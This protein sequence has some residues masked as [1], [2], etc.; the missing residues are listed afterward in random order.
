MKCLKYIGWNSYNGYSFETSKYV[1]RTRNYAINNYLYDRSKIEI[2]DVKI[3]NFQSK[4]EYLVK[5]E[6]FFKLLPNIEELRL[7]HYLMSENKIN[8]KIEKLLKLL[9]FS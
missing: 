2:N 8:Q 4:K 9:T 6:L 3:F 1:F 7:F 5:Q